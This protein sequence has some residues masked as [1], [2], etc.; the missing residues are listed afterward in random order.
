MIIND[1]FATLL[2][3]SNNKTHTLKK[4]RQAILFCQLKQHTQMI[5]NYLPGFFTF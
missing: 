3:I 2:Q 4:S 1:Q 5:N